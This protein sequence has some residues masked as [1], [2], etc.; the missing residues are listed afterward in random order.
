MEAFFSEERSNLRS[1]LVVKNGFDAK[2]TKLGQIRI[3]PPGGVG[4]LTD[5]KDANVM[6]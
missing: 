6:V 5:K 2:K 4:S 1:S 3:T